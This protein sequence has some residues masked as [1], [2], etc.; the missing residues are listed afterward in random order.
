M[1]K[2]LFASA[3]AL[4]FTFTGSTVVSCG[5]ND[6]YGNADERIRCRCI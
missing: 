4:A 5:G 1:K 3:V 2:F 6:N